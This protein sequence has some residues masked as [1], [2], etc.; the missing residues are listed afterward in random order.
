MKNNQARS[1]SSLL[2]SR[3]LRRLAAG[4]S[5]G[6]ICAATTALAAGGANTP[7]QWPMYGLN[8]G[9]NAVVS[10]NFPEV[11]WTY[12]VPGAAHAAKV[13]VLNSTI[14]RDL[15][16]FP[17]GV[18]VVDGMVYATNDNGYIYAVDAH[19][20]KLAWSFNA[21]NQ[22]MTTPIVAAIDGRPLVFIGAGNSVF[23]YSHAKQFGV[24]GAQVIRGNGV[25]AIYALDAK[26]GDEVWVHKTKGEDMPT[27]A[28]YQGK[29]LFGNGD[30]HA[31]ALDAATGKLAWQTPIHSFVSM[32]SATLDPARGVLVMGGT[33]P[34]KIYGLDAATG[35]L[36]WSVEPPL[37]FSSSAGDGTWAMDGKGLA[38]GQ[39]ETRTSAQQATKESAS[40]ELAIDLK[41]GKIVWSTELGAGKTPPRNKDAVPTVVDGVVYTGSPVT[42]TEYAVDAQTG[43]ILWQQPLKVSMKAAPVVVGKVLIQATASGEIFTLD[44]DSG[45]VLHTYNAHQGGYGPQNGVVVGG[46]YFN[47]TNAGM[48]QAIPLSTLG[49]TGKS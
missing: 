47:G 3:P 35:R 16:G 45:A 34:S 24:P 11:A 32:S 43:R 40:E 6:A 18:A 30:G 19:S 41:T 26:T 25:S 48:L 36:L 8:P 21:Y 33:H 10:S 42:H 12:Q 2:S 46:T 1:P 37:V 9:H 49:V 23:A 44:R 31:Y 38:V 4:L 20:G 39:I 13:K 28:L 17:I 5:F 14:I 15:V 22:L 29:L 7:T 27:P